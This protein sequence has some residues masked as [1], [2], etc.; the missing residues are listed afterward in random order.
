MQGPYKKNRKN[1]AGRLKRQCKQKALIASSLETD[2]NKE[3]KFVGINARRQKKI[4]Q[5]LSG[6]K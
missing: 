6:I 5:R 3:G 2:N 1:C 4:K